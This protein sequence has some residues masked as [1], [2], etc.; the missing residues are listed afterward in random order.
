MAVRT[1]N[2]SFDLRFKDDPESKFYE[3]Q[4]PEINI[5][6][7]VGSSIPLTILGDQFFLDKKLVITTNGV[8]GI[9]YRE[10]LFNLNKFYYNEQ[11]IYFV[12]R[13]KTSDEYPVKNLPNFSLLDGGFNLKVDILDKNNN[14]LDINYKTFE[15]PVSS[16]NN[17]SGG[18]FK[19]YITI[20]EPI[21][22]IKIKCSG[23]T[24]VGL[25]TGESNFFNIY[26]KN[27]NNQ[28]RK[29][30]EDFDQKK[31]YKSLRY[32]ETLKNK[33][34]FFDNFLGKIVGDKNSDP[35]TLGIKTYEKIS[36]FVSNVA[37]IDKS[38]IRSFYSMQNLIGSDISVNSITFPAS[39]QR[40][41]DMFSIN[42]SLLKGNIN[43]FN[44]DYDNK[45]LIISKTLGKNKGEF[46]PFT[47]TT[48]QTGISSKKI[49]AY[50]RFSEKYSLLDTNILSAKEFRYLDEQTRTYALSDYNLTWG[51]NLVIP[52]GMGVVDTL[53]FENSTDNTKNTNLFGLNLNLQDNYSRLLKQ[54]V[55]F[56]KNYVGNIGNF[57]DFYEYVPTYQGDNIQKFIDFDNDNTSLEYL[58]SYRD[59]Y[60]DSGP[61]DEIITNSL[62]KSTVFVET[63]TENN[64]TPHYMYSPS[65]IRILAKTYDKHLELYNLGYT[66]YDPLNNYD[67]PDQ[68]TNSSSGNTSTATSNNTQS[69][70]SYSPY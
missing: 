14:K 40:L 44:F 9:G 55:N 56:D 4:I 24:K 62:L 16:I 5:L 15:T 12:C 20:D 37:D 36:N 38:N 17:S 35:N 3:T 34:N 70:P 8:D 13:V 31:Y 50:E 57:Y 47:Q 26:E 25:L 68:T 29:I 39:I 2:A 61:V 33:D 67:T 60:S 45:G 65:G 7:T 42:L 28:I 21:N 18:Y 51:W 11:K 66:H 63:Y 49:V 43:Y 64:F 41:V 30:N 59:F 46:L 23:A 69:S 32:Q 19:G 54:T 48:L 27:G 1:I 10:N 58:S 22:D 6:N 53:T 52:K